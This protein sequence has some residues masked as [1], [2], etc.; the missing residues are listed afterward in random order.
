L[1][2]QQIRISIRR[3]LHI[4]SVS[5]S[6]VTSLTHNCICLRHFQDIGLV[7]D[8]G[9]ES[10]KTIGIGIGQGRTSHGGQVVVTIY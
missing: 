4:K 3:I 8:T 9:A 2:V 1:I 7:Y 10:N 5:N 6:S